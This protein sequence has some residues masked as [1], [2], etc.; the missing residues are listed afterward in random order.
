MGE[1]RLADDDN[2]HQV[3]MRSYVTGQYHTANNSGLSS[4]EHWTS[5]YIFI[6]DAAQ[7]TGQDR[8][9]GVCLLPY[10]VSCATWKMN[11]RLLRLPV[12]VPAVMALCSL[13]RTLQ[14]L[15]CILDKQNSLAW[16]C[17][18]YKMTISTSEGKNSAK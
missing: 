8:G 18:T 15:H 5:W 3:G 4:K 13:S 9:Q 17:W 1:G 11:S 6:F 12:H 7:D 2:A 14:P 10:P 16:K